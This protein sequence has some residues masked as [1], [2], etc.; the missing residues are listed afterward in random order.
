VIDV[1]LPDGG[2]GRGSSD[3]MANERKY[4]LL[5]VAL[6]VASVL[7]VLLTL[8]MFVWP[9]SSACNL[10]SHCKKVVL[11]IF[12]GNAIPF[13][14]GAGWLIFRTAKRAFEKYPWAKKI[15]F[16]LALGFALFLVG[17]RYLLSVWVGE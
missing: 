16:A 4:T 3:K 14:L 17:C 12:F 11:S 15:W 1:S 9:W 7:S 5:N 13:M 10:D 8:V 6:D 2:G